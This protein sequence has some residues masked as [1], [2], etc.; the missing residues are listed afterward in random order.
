MCNGTL[1]QTVK[2][3]LGKT[4][5]CISTQFEKE[6]YINGKPVKDN[7]SIDLCRGIIEY[8]ERNGFLN[9]ERY[10]FSL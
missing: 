7:T 5:E 10:S 4:V 2:T 6:Y 3:P 9:E 1:I 8:A